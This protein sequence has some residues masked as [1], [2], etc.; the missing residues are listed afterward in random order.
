V[1]TR[2]SLDGCAKSRPFPHR[3]S[4]PDRPGRSKSL[5]GLR[6]PGPQYDVVQRRNSYRV[7]ANRYEPIPYEKK[8]T[9]INSS[10]SYRY[11][12]VSCRLDL[13][14]SCEH[15]NELSVSFLF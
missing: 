14:A 12:A 15:G 13:S 11:K 5:K 9:G 2:D 3:D 8:S 10:L 7:L 6:D 4:I 1:G